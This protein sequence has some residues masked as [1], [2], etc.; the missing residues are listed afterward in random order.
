VTHRIPALGIAC[1]RLT[2]VL[3][4]PSRTRCFCLSDVDYSLQ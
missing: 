3:I 1:R 4:K 2:V